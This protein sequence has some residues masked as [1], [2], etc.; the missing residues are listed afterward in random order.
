VVLWNEGVDETASATWATYTHAHL[1]S[2]AQ[3][4]L[5]ANASSV[6]TEFCA[7]VHSP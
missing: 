2:S 6:S 3:T 4:G 1:Q 5:D 7:V